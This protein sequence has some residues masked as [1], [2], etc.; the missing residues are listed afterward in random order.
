[1]TRQLIKTHFSIEDLID[2]GTVKYSVMF[3][4]I[5]FDLGIKNKSIL[6]FS[7]VFMRVNFE[8]IQEL[9]IQ[10]FRIVTRS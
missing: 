4:C 9:R 10:Q 2:L 5:A 7:F 1:M 8:P 6:I 3:F